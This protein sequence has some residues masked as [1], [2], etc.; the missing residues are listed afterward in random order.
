MTTQHRNRNYAV[1]FLCFLALYII[2]YLFVDRP[3]A[4]SL[5]NL[6]GTPIYHIAKV[7]SHLG[8]YKIWF[9]VSTT[10]MVVSAALIWKG[11]E[12]SNP[13]RKGLYFICSIFVAIIVGGFFKFVL[14][15][16]RPEMLF[17][18]NLYGFHFFSFKN[19]FSSTPSGHA[20]VI[21]A[22]CTALSILFRRYAVLFFLIA[23]LVGVS[24]VVLEAH[25]LS[26]VLFG[27]YIGV[28]AAV[29]CAKGSFF[30]VGKR[31][32]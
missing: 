5:E 21:F 2:F 20:L 7:I 1:S 31:V 32:A 9:I 23:V 3:L 18:E 17:Q 8:N 13:F 12:F 16:Y 6:N 11:Y 19:H 29:G 27:G 4:Y 24:R 30:G 25:Y 28:M 10:I 14:A 15:R 26:D 22:V